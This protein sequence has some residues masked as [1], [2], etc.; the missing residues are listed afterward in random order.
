MRCFNKNERTFLKN[1]C[2]KKGDL[3]AESHFQICRPV[4]KLISADNDTFRGAV[5]CAHI[6]YGAP[7]RQSGG[8][9]GRIYGYRNI[10]RTA[11]ALYNTRESFFAPLGLHDDDDFIGTQ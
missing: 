6:F 5:D 4:G 9:R 2:N 8:E 7:D 10:R 11:R 3:F 1:E